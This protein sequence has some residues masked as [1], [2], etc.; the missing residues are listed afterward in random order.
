MSEGV[1]WFIFGTIL[2]A[3][4]VH[5]P[6]IKPA[7]TKRTTLEDTA[8]FKFPLCSRFILDK[9]ESTKERTY[10]LITMANETLRLY[11]PSTLLDIHA[12]II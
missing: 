6:M 4:S 7:R 9:V 1:P 3:T 5:L 2:L 10:K 12:L 8:P 11:D